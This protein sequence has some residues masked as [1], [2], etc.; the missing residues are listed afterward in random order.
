MLTAAKPQATVTSRPNE[1]C[2][3]RLQALEKYLNTRSDGIAV[4]APC[5]I[6]VRPTGAGEPQAK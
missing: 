6:F 4:K 1:V 5:R 2:K 3:V